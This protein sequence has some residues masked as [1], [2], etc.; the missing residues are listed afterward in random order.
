MQGSGSCTMSKQT[1]PAQPN[2]PRRPNSS[3]IS[4]GSAPPL[5]LLREAHQLGSWTELDR[6][7]LLIGR[8]PMWHMW[9]IRH[10]RRSRIR[11]IG[12]NKRNA[13]R[14][15]SN[16][17]IERPATAGLVC[18]TAFPDR[19]YALLGDRL[20]PATGNRA[21][22]SSAPCDPSPKPHSPEPLAPHLRG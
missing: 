2:Y 4:T 21:C 14:L 20:S 10:R 11:R 17:I 19:S 6:K 12:D 7:R 18:H 8:R 1:S 16:E 9:R 5:H 22:S 13:S 3:D 15:P